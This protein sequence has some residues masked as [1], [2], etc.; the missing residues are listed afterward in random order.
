MSKA[1]C[2]VKSLAPANARTS[3]MAASQIT[4]K[5]IP[6]MVNQQRMHRLVNKLIGCQIRYCQLE[7]LVD[8]HTLMIVQEETLHALRGNVQLS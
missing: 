2:T 8:H 7:F 1:H 5:S 3:G 6:L 4:S